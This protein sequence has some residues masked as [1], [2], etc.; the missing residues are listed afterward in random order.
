VKTLISFFFLASL[1]YGAQS[2]TIPIGTTVYGPVSLDTALHKFGEL[3]FSA[4]T[5]TNPAIKMTAVIDYSDDGRKTWKFLCGFKAEGMPGGPPRARWC[6]LYDL[7]QVDDGKQ[8]QRS[9]NATDIR[10][11]VTVTGGSITISAI[12]NLGGKQ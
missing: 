6:P 7:I 1:A 10:A 9:R 3:R 2:I 11:T 5:W 12:P 4:P 8:A